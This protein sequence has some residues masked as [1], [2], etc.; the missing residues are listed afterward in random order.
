MAGQ[1]R[2]FMKK[3]KSSLGS[4]M[5]PAEDPRQTFADAYTRQQASLGAIRL[6]AADL[7]A[8]RARLDHQAESL[9]ARL[10]DLEAQARR[11]VAIGREDLARLALR[12]RYVA[13]AELQELER[14]A[15]E[16]Q[17][18]E[19]RL[20]MVEQRLASQLESISARQQVVAARHSAADAELRI[21]EALAGVS[22]DL[23]DLGLALE[24]AEQR[25]EEMQAQADAIEHLLGSSLLEGAGTGA[26]DPL[27]QTLDRH[28]M[29]QAIEEQ[30]RALERQQE[31][32]G[33]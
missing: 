28:D 22:T 4:L 12:R 18:E 8:A 9:R 2:G 24:R 14:Q 19:G 21:N 7:S 1:P 32:R 17:L 26:L 33:S 16:I 3:L 5:A 25:Q 27:Q 29:E 31:G 13:I 11:A 20:T 15:G 10:P 23:S 6:A 30:L